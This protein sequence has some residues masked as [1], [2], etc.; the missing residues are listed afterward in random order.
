VK[1]V[2]YWPGPESPD[3]NHTQSWDVYDGKITLK[4]LSQKAENDFRK[5]CVKLSSGL[6]GP[7][8]YLTAFTRQSRKKCAKLPSGLSGPG[9]YLT[10]F[11]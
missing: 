11:T 9:Q 5:K 3:G 2:R 4:Y 1:A 10:V 6:S 8:Q 7:G